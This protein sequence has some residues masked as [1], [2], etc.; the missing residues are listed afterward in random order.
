M[1]YVEFPNTLSSEALANLSPYEIAELTTREPEYYHVTQRIA[2][3]GSFS[4]TTLALSPEANRPG[5]LSTPYRTELSRAGN[6]YYDEAGDLLFET[7]LSTV[8]QAWLEG[9]EA[10]YASEGHL[11]LADL[12]VPENDEV[13]A[14]QMEGYS[15]ATT[16]NLMIISGADGTV[17]LDLASPRTVT[18]TLDELSGQPQTTVSL[19][20]ELTP[21]QGRLIS[22][23]VTTLR[24]LTDGI[25]YRETELR[26]RKYDGIPATPRVRSSDNGIAAIAPV[27]TVLPSRLSRWP[28]SHARSRSSEL[29]RAWLTRLC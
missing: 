4:S 2:A 11:P 23:S 19:Y 16:Q 22:Q 1:H 18:H 27:W 13:A 10:A 24:T 3:D 9:Y 8:Q 28:H 14:L 21:D 15:V 6:Q 12:T 17:E 29:K 26:L 5:A 20:E 7:P 25:C